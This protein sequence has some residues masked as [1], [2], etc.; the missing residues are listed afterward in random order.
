ML[1]NVLKLCLNVDFRHGRSKGL[2][3]LPDSSSLQSEGA[4]LQSIPTNFF[5]II[6]MQRLGISCHR[7]KVPRSLK[8]LD[9]L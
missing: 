4:N 9:N 5:K 2:V 3:F 7:S 6:E 1:L 8:M